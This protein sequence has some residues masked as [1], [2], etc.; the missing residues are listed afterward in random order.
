MKKAKA[1][2]AALSLLLFLAPGAKAKNDPLGSGT[3]KLTLDK[4]LL[5]YLAHND[6]KLKAKQGAKLGAKTVSLP[7]VGG[8]MD[9]AAGMGEIAQQGTLVIEGKHGKVPLREI[10]IKTKKTPLIAKVGGSQLKVAT[11]KRIS[12]KRNGFGSSFTATKLTLTAKVA[13][14]LQKKLRPKLPFKEGQ[15]LGS[16]TAKPQPELITIAEEGKA[17]LLFDPTFAQK[18]EAHFVS[19][20]PL[21]PAEHQG[22]IFTFPIA[23]GGALAPDASQGTLRTAG[24]IEALQLHG[25]QLFWHEPWLDLGTHQASSE[26]EL[27]PAPPLPGKLTRAG[28]FEVGPAPVASD[29]KA[30]TISVSGAPLTL[31]AQS[32]QQLNLAFAE[33]KADFNAG[34]AV[35]TVGFVAVGE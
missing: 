7:V 1:A 14:R 18:L 24:A 22:L 28:A 20:N 6:L 27:L 32:A 26:A 25:G 35:G 29:P 23:A 11:A 33:G 17:T 31:S 3:T 8:S 34:E 4:G 21:F 10:T 13:T 9:L 16:L 2:I 15:P 19:L 30:R 5:S 12:S